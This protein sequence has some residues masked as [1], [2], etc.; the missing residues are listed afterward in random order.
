MSVLLQ[1]A[2]SDTVIGHT[3]HTFVTAT[4]DHSMD[5]LSV[6]MFGHNPAAEGFFLSDM[7]S[8]HMMHGQE[9]HRLHLPHARTYF[10]VANP[11]F[12]AWEVVPLVNPSKFAI[13]LP[14]GDELVS[15]P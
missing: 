4:L 6:F 15:W 12:Q 8:V 9:L 3:V 5:V 2:N 7:R 11:V 1:V 13:P 14:S 10:P